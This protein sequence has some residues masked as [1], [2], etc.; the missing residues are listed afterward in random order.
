M[1]LTNAFPPDVRVYKEAKYLVSKGNKVT[2]L[3][4][5]KTPEWGLPS[6]EVIDGISIV[7]FGIPAI[8]GTGLKQL[9]AYYKY[10]KCCKKY[11]IWNSCDHLHCHDLD[12]SLAGYLARKGKT[13]YVFD[14]HEF[15]EKGRK[16]KK[17][18]I[19]NVVMKLV[20]KAQAVIYVSNK[21][22]ETYGSDFADK[23]HILRNYSNPNFF[24]DCEKVKS[25]IFR[26]SYIGEVR[27]QVPE[28]VALFDAVKGMENV[29]V[30]IYGGGPDLEKLKAIQD[31]YSNVRVHGRYNGISESN[32]I[33]ANTDVSFVAYNA[34][35][36]NYQGDFEPVKLYEAIFTGTPIIATESINPGKIA[37]SEG[38]GLAVDTKNPEAIRK[39]IKKFIKNKLFY[40]SC[41]EN[42]K[43]AAH[44]FD[45]NVAV[46][47]LDKI[48]AEE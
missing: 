25:N 4:W 31:R 17:T 39:A 2:V 48:Y 8:A 21:S 32:C 35:N 20:K 9:G 34:Q 43:M 33:Y 42:M 23:F 47:V 6:N 16:I 5:D 38:F 29:K 19:H 41:A 18:L 12:G 28:F 10:I 37:R 36:P 14:M 46:T 13:P 7:R 11:L 1:I 40:I 27:N 15:Y 45:W 44:K 30:D 22:L 26:V 24:L 3:C